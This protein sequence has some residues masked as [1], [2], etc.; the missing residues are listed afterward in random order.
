MCVCGAVLG[1][2]AGAS[3]AAM[4]GQRRAEQ[5]GGVEQSG[6]R[7]GREGRMISAARH[8]RHS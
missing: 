4:D 3:A 2:V 7:K 6:Q 1:L 8:A 5:H